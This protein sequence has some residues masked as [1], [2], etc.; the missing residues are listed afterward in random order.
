MTTIN[1]IGNN[2][3]HYRSSLGAN[4]ALKGAVAS[5]KWFAFDN[6]GIDAGATISLQILS[7]ESNTLE[8]LSAH[9]ISHIGDTSSI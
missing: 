3:S 8:Q 2:L 6:M 1:N 4:D 7:G 5:D 9:I